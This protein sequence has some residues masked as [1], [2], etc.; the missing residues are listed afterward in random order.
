MMN[1]PGLGLSKL[2]HELQQQVTD[3][4]WLLLLHPVAGAVD[5]MTA[6]HAR[7]GG[8]LHRL[9]YAGALVCAPILSARDEAGGNIDGAA[10]ISL[11]FGDERAR[12][13]ATIP[14]Q[15]ALESGAGIFRA[16]EG[17]LAVGQPFV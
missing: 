6:E 12:G 15:P 17:E 2:L 16:A 4:L 5:Q 9:E 14:L 7:A 1:L 3:L 13:A 8:G 10:G 11:E